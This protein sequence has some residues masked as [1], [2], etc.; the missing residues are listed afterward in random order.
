MDNSIDNL[1]SPTI[2]CSRYVL[3]MEIHPRLA[4]KTKKKP[5]QNAKRDEH[6]KRAYKFLAT[7]HADCSDLIALVRETGTVMREVRDIEDQIE[8]EKNR[9]I[10]SNLERI[11]ADLTLVENEGKELQE[12]IKKASDTKTS[13]K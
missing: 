12:K 8:N 13:N 10:S 4:A 11:T 3:C 1:Q 2:L 5:F 7:L 9:N 6:S